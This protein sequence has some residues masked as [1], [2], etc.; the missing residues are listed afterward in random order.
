MARRLSIIDG[1]AAIVPA[2]N[3]ERVTHAPDVAAVTPDAQIE[4]LAELP[5]VLERWLR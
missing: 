4:S 1:V 2:R 3:L 5:E